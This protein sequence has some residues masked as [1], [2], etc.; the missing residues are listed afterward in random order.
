MDKLDERDSGRPSIPPVY[1]VPE[2]EPADGQASRT[3]WAKQSDSRSS[4]LK[5]ELKQVPPKVT[6]YCIH[7]KEKYAPYCTTC[8]ISFAVFRRKEEQLRK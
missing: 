3:D 2:P 1:E 8:V 5:P 7:K 4:Q 6:Y